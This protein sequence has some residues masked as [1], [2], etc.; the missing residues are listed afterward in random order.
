MMSQFQR[1][2]ITS[3]EMFIQQVLEPRG[4][5]VDDLERF[6]R[7]YMGVQELIATIGL[8]RQAGHAAGDP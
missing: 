3:P 1:A 5:E 7:H 6:V 4:F 8:E 2:G